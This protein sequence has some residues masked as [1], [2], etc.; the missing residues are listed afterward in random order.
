MWKEHGTKIIG[1]ILTGL[2]AVS[3][4]LTPELI[5]DLLKLKGPSAALIAGGIMTF[6]RGLQNSGTLPGGPER[7]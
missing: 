3:M 6:I 4:M 7:K 2:G 1:A 5:I